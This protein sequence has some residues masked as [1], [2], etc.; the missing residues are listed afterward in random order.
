VGVSS[1]QGLCGEA[2]ENDVLDDNNSLPVSSSE[3]ATPS[4]G[5]P[6][7]QDAEALYAEGMAHYRRREWK[8]ARACFARL[9]S[10]APDRRGVDALLNEIDIFIQL[11]EMQPE[12]DITQVG[13]DELEALRPVE[14][15]VSVEPEPRRATRHRSRFLI[16]ALLVLVG[17]ASV[18]IYRTGVLDAVIGNQ[19]QAR[20]QALVNQGRAAMNVG[21]YDRAVQAFGEALA[22]APNSEDVKTWY[23]KARRYQDFASWYAEAE[24]AI[25][26]Q[27]WDDAMG[28]LEQIVA[29]DP[30]YEDASDRME[31][32]RGQQALEA[33]FE[34]ATTFTEESNWDKAIVTLTQLREQDATYKSIEVTQ[35][36][37]NAY[38]QKG[39]ALLKSA[40]DSLDLINGAIESFDNALLIFPSDAAALEEKRLADLYRQGHLSANQ[41]DWPQAISALEEIYDT[42]PDYQ[43]GR[44]ASLLCTSYLHLG[45]AYE[46]V[47]DLTQALEQYQS[48]L[49]IEGCD[50]VEAAVKEREIL[51]TLYPPT[52]TPTST[53][54][55]TRTPLPTPTSTIT[56]TQTPAPPT[57]PPPPPPRPTST[58]RIP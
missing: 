57:P 45:E 19:R 38:F 36:L 32:V 27:R 5:G 39:M 49:N 20:V 46:T 43:E 44:V 35:S 8:E 30:T 12:S 11:Q 58:R 33:L 18:A 31:F 40:G 10:M 6:A 51:A 21:E 7:A 16:I 15:V 4:S 23:A 55:A 42:R 25:A 3:V 54:M 14:P 56:P 37:F 24:A 50:H 9:K 48:V 17:A 34:Q 2:K 29:L 22:L 41:E 26:E 1:G 52:A 13:V 47:G 53:P 28:W